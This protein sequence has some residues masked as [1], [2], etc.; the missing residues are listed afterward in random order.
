M[1]GTPLEVLT[2]TAAEAEAD[3]LMIRRAGSVAEARSM[4][5][6]AQQRMAG[7][8]AMSRGIMTAGARL[9]GGAAKAFPSKGGPSVPKTEGNDYYGEL[10]G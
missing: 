9:L 6:A 7:K 10:Y 3:A 4:A 5:E 2:E 8:A 1:E